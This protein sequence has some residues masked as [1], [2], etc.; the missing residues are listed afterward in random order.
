MSELENSQVTPE[1]SPDA[2]NAPETPAEATPSTSEVAVEA[3]PE[4]AAA[5]EALQ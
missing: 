4:G 2:S 1:T 3:A 5:A